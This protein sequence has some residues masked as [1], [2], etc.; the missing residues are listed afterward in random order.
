[1]AAYVIG[2]IEV[3]DP[4][5]YEEYRKQ[6][7]AVVTKYGGK[8]IVRGGRSEA[9]EGTA[10]KRLVVLEFPTMEQALK[11]YRS[12]EYAPLIKLR[13]KASKGKLVLVEGA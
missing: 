13:Q 6:V 12:P 10:P 2:E 11:W 4:G 7:L 3:T 9:L 1:M 5:P 8:F